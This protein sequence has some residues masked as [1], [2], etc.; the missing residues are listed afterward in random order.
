MTP[1][2]GVELNVLGRMVNYP[3][4]A[5]QGLAMHKPAHFA[6]PQHRRLF[7][8]VGK[9]LE[10]GRPF[11]PSEVG[12]HLAPEEWGTLAHATEVGIDAGSVASQN[13]TAYSLLLL[14]QGVAR[15]A[16]EI[17]ARLVGDAGPDGVGRALAELRALDSLRGARE[18]EQFADVILRVAQAPDLPAVATG[19][20][21]L[22]RVVRLEPCTLA[23]VAARPGVGK[24][25]FLVSM[26][27]DAASLGWNVL[28]VTIEMSKAELARRHSRGLKPGAAE[29]LAVLQLDSPRVAEVV[30]AARRFAAS[31]VRPL[32]MIDYLQLV[33]P[34][35]GYN[36]RWEAVGE[37]VRELKALAMSAEVP[38][39]VAAQLSRATEQRPG[40][41]PELADLRESGETEQA[42]DVVIFLHRNE[43]EAELLV[44]KNR[45]GS[46]GLVPLTFIPAQ[47]RFFPRSGASSA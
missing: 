22:D 39:I 26:G 32:V 34:D 4:L 19:F 28:L 43:S 37:V 23:V 27:T 36:A 10:S 38:V 40:K 41:R 15:E 21:Q 16:R 44:A 29:G 35:R 31:R 12:R 17:G 9:A 6:A 46:L 20:P 42:A 2:W 45:H 24:T 25:A 13:L 11:V 14:E 3:D 18:P 1:E 7:E 5:R 8:A 47:V 33:R 30:A